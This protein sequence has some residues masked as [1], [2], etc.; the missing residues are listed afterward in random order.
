MDSLF[1]I[2]PEKKNVLE[3]NYH[4]LLLI[5]VNLSSNPHVLFLNL[6]TL[7]TLILKNPVV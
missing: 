5:L 1:S 3:K 4:W 6:A 2:I 7:K